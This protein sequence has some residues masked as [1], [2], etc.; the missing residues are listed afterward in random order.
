[1][2]CHRP[3]HAQPRREQGDI[4]AQACSA[5]LNTN[6]DTHPNTSKSKHVDKS[7]HVRNRTQMAVHAK[8]QTKHSMSS[9]TCAVT[10]RLTL[11]RDKSKVKQAHSRIEQQHFAQ[12]C[13]ATYV[14]M[15]AR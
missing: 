1:M 13:T 12:N 15:R 6:G 3:P 8:I 2:L 10:D 7:K 11:S 4:E 9:Q 5:K 14:I